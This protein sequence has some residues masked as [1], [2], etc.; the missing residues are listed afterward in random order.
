MSQSGR[1]GIL[2]PV[3]ATSS[4]TTR[5]AATFTFVPGL[6]DPRCYSLKDASGRYLRHYA[7]RIRLD[8][9]DGSVLFQKDATFC[10]RSGSTPGSVSLESYN[11]PGRYLRHRGG[12]Q[13]WLDPSKNTAA[14]RTS[15][16]FVLVAPW[17]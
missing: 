3:G 1:L 15:R 6:A 4:V 14:N 16:S 17:T 7:F 11:Y 9:D 2:G 10:P 12:L 8:N 5:Q 13:L